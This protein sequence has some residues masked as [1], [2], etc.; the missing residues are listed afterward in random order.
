MDLIQEIYKYLEY[1]IRQVN[2]LI[3]K[4]ASVEEELI[5]IISN[6]LLNAGGKRIRPILTLLT[7]KLF[8][9]QG[10]NHI[11]LAA[12]V[13]LIHMATILHDD[14]VDGSKMRRF[15]PS[16]NEIWGSKASILVGDFLFSQSFRLIVSTKSLQALQILSDSSAIIAQGEVSQLATLESNEMISKEKYINIINAKTAELFSAAASVSAVISNQSAQYFNALREYAKY[17]G[18]IFQISDDLL[19]YLGNQDETGKNTGDDLKEG[20]VTLPLILLYEKIDHK[21]KQILDDIIYQK[22]KDIKNFHWTA[23]QMVR[24]NIQD[25]IIQYLQSIKI[26]ALNNIDK[27]NIENKSKDYLLQLIDFAMYRKS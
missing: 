19:D 24:Y 8:N 5:E 20:K 2:E 18:Q 22:N 17:L 21:E 3:I 14:V 15:I 1:D 27:I 12:A 23:S 13:E 11:S 26:K 9:Y 4:T 7:A 6:H 25:D 16:A 10:Q